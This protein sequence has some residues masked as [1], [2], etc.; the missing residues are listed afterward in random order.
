MGLN[1]QLQQINVY[2][3]VQGRYGIQ[4]L[5]HVFNAL[6]DM[7]IIQLRK[8]VF[9]G[10][11]TAP[12]S[13]TIAHKMRPFGM[14]IRVY[15]AF[16]QAIGTTIQ[17]DAKT[18]NQDITMILGSSSARSAQ[19]VMSLTS[20]NTHAFILYLS[21]QAVTQLQ[22]VHL[23]L[24]LILLRICVSH[25]QAALCS[26]LLQIFA[27]QAHQQTAHLTLSGMASNV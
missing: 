7:S 27:C 4:L 3:A 10:V 24:I 26:I 15:N 6:V 12:I 5:V 18:V 17:A 9:P 20:T 2:I 16:C 11:E 23:E 21:V 13:L 1:G 14:E 22:T 25:A 19:V 8:C